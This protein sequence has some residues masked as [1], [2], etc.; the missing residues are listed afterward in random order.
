MTVQES[1]YKFNTAVILAGGKSSRMGFDKQF[2][3]INNE[4]LMKVVIAKLKNEFNEII[5]VTNK[6][7]EYR[8]FNCKII[9]DKI[10]GMGPLSG[11][12]AGLI[13]SSSE[14]IYVMACDMPNVNLQYVRY[15]KGI[16]EKLDIDVCV[17]MSRDGIEPFHGFYS[18]KLIDKIEEYLSSN[19]RSLNG[20]ILISNA[21][22]VEE[23]KAREFSPD[24]SMFLNLNTEKDLEEFFSMNKKFQ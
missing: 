6:P 15:L 10:K 22:L 8:D 12:H 24:L 23:E 20:L 18:K 3:E 17:T 16:I 9:S 5:I 7:E 1:K 13:E 4:R 11:I 21:Y 14:Y 19:R 2:L